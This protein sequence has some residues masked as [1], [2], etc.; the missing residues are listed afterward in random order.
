MN[1]ISR[2]FKERRRYIIEYW[3]DLYRLFRRNRGFI[4][5]RLSHNPQMRKAKKKQNIDI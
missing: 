2:A 5:F 1:H 3:R 4:M